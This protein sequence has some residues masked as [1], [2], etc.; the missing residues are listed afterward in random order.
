MTSALIHHTFTFQ[1]TPTKKADIKLAHSLS[2]V[3]LTT[4]TGFMTGRS[5]NQTS[6][7]TKP[8]MARDQGG[9][10]WVIWKPWWGFC[11][12][13]HLHLFL[14]GKKGAWVLNS[15]PSFFLPLMWINSHVWCVAFLDFWVFSIGLFC[16][17]F[18]YFGG[19]FLILDIFID[20]LFWQSLHWK[21][22]MLWVGNI[23]IL[24]IFV[25]SI[26]QHGKCFHFFVS[27]SISSTSVL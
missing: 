21:C 1:S 24:A 17:G 19:R 26:C 25:L 14:L 8:R 20:Y 18:A 23:D 6:K 11:G 12:R 13:G 2:S 16:R 10:G 22:R 4:N 3:F 5:T 9:N 27:S 7:Q 15:T